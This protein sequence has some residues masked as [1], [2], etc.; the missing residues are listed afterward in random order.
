MPFRFRSVVLC[1]AFAKIQIRGFTYR[2]ND[3]KDSFRQNDMICGRLFALRTAMQC[4]S[5]DI[6]IIPTSDPHLSEYLPDHWRSR[7]WFSGFTGSAGTLVV[8]HDRASLWVDSRYWSQAARQLEGTGIDMCKVEGGSNIPYVEWITGNFPEGS[9]VGID[10]YLI[11]LNQGRLLKNALET[12]KFVF[13]T[14]TDPVSLV[15]KD[16]PRIPLKPVFEHK[17]K[18]VGLSRLEKIDQVRSEMKIRRADWYFVSTLDD[19]AWTLNLRGSDIEFNPVFVSYL[20]IGHETVFLMVDCEKIPADLV[21]I[22]EEDGVHIKPYETAADC[23]RQLPSGASLL[24]DPRRTA[25]AMAEV[26]GAGVR[27][28]ESINPTVLFKSRKSPKEIEHIRKTM[29]EDGAAFCEFQSWF[30]AQSGIGNNDRIS[31][32]TISEKIEVLRSVRTHYVSP[33]FG[34]IAGFNANAALPHYQATEEAFSFIDGDGLLLIDTGGQ[35]LSGT[36]DMTRVIPVGFPSQEQKRDFTV[37]L[38]GLIAL[39][40]SRFPRS[41]PAPM[42]DSI[43]R[44][45]LWSFGLDY[46]HGTGHGVGYFLNVHEGPQGI[47]YHANPESQTAMEEGMVTSIEPGLYREGKWGIRLENLVVNQVADDEEAGK[48][49]RFETLTQC[50]IDTRCIDK[51]LLTQEEI[52]WLNRYH[53]KVRENLLPLVADYARDWL[54]KRTEPV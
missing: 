44:K 40:E 33:S 43:A 42:L 25:Y 30:D 19:I 11:S 16:R 37:V 45:P 3:M 35:Y 18:F 17:S 4:Q 23:L 14:D 7:E 36:T 34:T 5:V 13:K 52:S 28:I 2:K 53:E 54:I 15:W 27:K 12:K 51:S 10:G 6:L 29:L 21:R 32:L 24:Y 49:L 39:S 26:V 38:K 46:G 50:P 48:F 31:E 9:V 22:L 41:I 8:G 1:H 47:S 20:L